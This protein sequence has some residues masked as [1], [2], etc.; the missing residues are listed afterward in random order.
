MPGAELAA[1]SP[2]MLVANPQAGIRTIPELIA[3]AKA[4]PGKIN[5]GTAGSGTPGHLAGELLNSLAGIQL[6]HVLYR[7]GAQTMTDLVA[8]QIELVFTGMPATLGQ[9]RA[10]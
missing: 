8:G 6:T 3:L 2:Q 4:K 9:I 1:I 5:Y 10:G 7:G